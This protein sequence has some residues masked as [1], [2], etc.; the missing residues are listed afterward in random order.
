MRPLPL[1]LAD[2]TLS[3]VR[4]TLSAVHGVSIILPEVCNPSTEWT[5]VAQPAVLAL[6]HP[7]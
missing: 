3:S 5:C 7:L 1:Q 4:D 6:T 2:F